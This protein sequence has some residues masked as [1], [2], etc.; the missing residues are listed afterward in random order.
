MTS[1]MDHSRRAI[2]G[3]QAII[4]EQ[5]SDGSPHCR[6]VG[7]GHG[8]ATR[9][10]R[11]RKPAEGCTNDRATASNAFKRDDTEWLCPSRR[12]RH[13]PMSCDESSQ[14]GTGFDPGESH[15]RSEVKFSNSCQNGRAFW[16]VT[17][18]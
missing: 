8:D 10:D 15:L 5:R 6:C 13:N 3:A 16:A 4:L 17:N 2:V 7:V 12:Y 9:T 1:E 11:L 14:V 18:D